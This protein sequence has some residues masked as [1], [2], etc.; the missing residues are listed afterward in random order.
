MKISLIVAMAIN[1]AIGINGQMPWHLSADLRH[2]KKITMGSPLIMGR[3]TFEA[4]GKPLPGRNNIIISRNSAYAQ[5]G[6]QTFIN[7]GDALQACHESEEVFVI[8][9]ATLYQALL[10]SSDFLYIT[11]INKAFAGDTFFPEIDFHNWREIERQEIT[12]D[13]TVDFHYSFV[14]L[15]R[16]QKDKC[17]QHG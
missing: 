1:R 17:D 4:I 3:K 8:G 6:C 7:I 5:S 15:E 2:F 13:D 11:E 14:K 16:F 9:G 12:D 10:A